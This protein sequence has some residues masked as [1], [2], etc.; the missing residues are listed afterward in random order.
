MP[1]SIITDFN[2]GVFSSY[3]RFTP[4]KESIVK[5]GFVFYQKTPSFF[6]ESSN[7]FNSST[8]PNQHQHPH[9]FFQ[10]QNAHASSIRP[11]DSSSQSASLDSTSFHY[12]TTTATAL[13][14]LLN[15]LPTTDLITIVSGRPDVSNSTKKCLQKE[16]TVIECNKNL[17]SPDTRHWAQTS[18]G[19]FVIK[20]GS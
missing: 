6:K 20:P 19:A 5:S 9:E 10:A 7:R 2:G 4:I 14:N 11:F 13:V 8:S 18:F 1:I 16:L 3:G 17:A 15:A 12:N